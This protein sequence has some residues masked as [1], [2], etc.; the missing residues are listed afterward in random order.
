MPTRIEPPAAA[1]VTDP[2]VPAIVSAMREGW[3]E[4]GALAAALS[5]RP[6]SL[7]TTVGLVETLYTK[8]G[9]DPVLL[10]LLRIQVAESRDDQYGMKIRV[11]QFEEAVEARRRE[12]VTGPD[13][14]ALQLADRSIRNPHSVDD[15]FFAVVQEHFTE[16]QIVGLQFAISVFGMASLIAIGLHLDTEPDS[17]YGSGLIYRQDRLRN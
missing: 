10:E 5:R 8:S 2:M 7:K 3:W 11:K 1:A 9:I 17:P 12:G 4:D 16:H 13:A 14:I 6:E 15:D